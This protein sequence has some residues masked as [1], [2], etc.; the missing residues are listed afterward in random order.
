MWYNQ[1][2]DMKPNCSSSNTNFYCDTSKS[3]R[4]MVV[5]IFLHFFLSME[6]SSV[7]LV[8]IQNLCEQVLFSRC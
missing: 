6:T 2:G 8:C 1:E 5:D 4:I 7:V 3:R